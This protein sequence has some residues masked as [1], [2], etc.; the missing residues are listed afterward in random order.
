MVAALIKSKKM[1]NSPTI[2]LFLI[3]HHIAEWPQEKEREEWRG[4]PSIYLGVIGAAAALFLLTC[5]TE[6][7]HYHQYEE[8]AWSGNGLV[9]LA[10]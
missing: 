4:K 9:R 8:V 7:Y 10:L 6:C 2:R 1:E 3:C 5:F